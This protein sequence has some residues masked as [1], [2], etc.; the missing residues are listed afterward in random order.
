MHYYQQFIR[1]FFLVPFLLITLLGGY[2]YLFYARPQSLLLM[3]LYHQHKTAYAQSIKQPKIL[4]TSGSNTLYGINTLEIEEAL[5][6]PTVNL[7]VN[8]G[9]NHDYIFHK[10]KEVL[11]AGDII[12]VVSEYQHLRWDGELSRTK[13]EYILS[14]DRAY[15]DRL[16]LLEKI[17]II[18]TVSLKD[19]FLSISEQYHFD[20][21]AYQE[22]LETTQKSLNSHGDKV[23]KT[24]HKPL[25]IDRTGLGLPLEKKYTFE[26]QGLHELIAFNQWCQA[27]HVTLY[28]TFPNTV[29]FEV[30]HSKHYTTYFNQLLAFYQKNHL[31]YLGEPQAFFYP[32]R[33]FYDTNYH[34]N[35][36][37]ASLRTQ[38]LIEMM[39]TQIRELDQFASPPNPNFI[40]KSVK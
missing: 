39:R 25:E 6:I 24:G 40:Q 4:F 11:K 13:N 20:K 5:H 2:V 8:A 1:I 36:Q 23:D 15:F 26:T 28:L 35:T 30:Y 10:A 29:E 22:G 17:K 19:I 34:L 3:H 27:H 12:I 18:N 9:L 37:G 31:R 38:Q 33:Y 7:A 14:Y 16:P 32:K 21:S